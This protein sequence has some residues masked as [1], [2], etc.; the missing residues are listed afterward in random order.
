M[1]NLC[2]LSKWNH[3]LLVKVLLGFFLLSEA[4]VTY[5]KQ[6]VNHH[7]GITVIKDTL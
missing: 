5:W 4:P 7:L 2:I 6:V 3:S 1:Y